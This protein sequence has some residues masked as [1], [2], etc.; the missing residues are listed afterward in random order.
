MLLLPQLNH[1]NFCDAAIKLGVSHGL[2]RVSYF[3]KGNKARKWASL[4]ICEIS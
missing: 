2:V 1:M 4:M 3:L